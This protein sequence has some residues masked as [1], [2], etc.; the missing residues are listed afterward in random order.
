MLA[1]K[2]C[3]N[4]Y[5]IVNNNEKENVTV[6]VTGNAAGDLAPTFILFAGKSLPRNAADMAPAD[7]V[8]GCSD[9]GYMTSQNFYEYMANFFEPWL[10]ECR[11]K[12]PVLFYVDRHVWHM[13]LH[14]S[15]FCADRGIILIGLHPN[16]THLA[17]PLDV[18]LFHTLKDIWFKVVREFCEKAYCIGIEKYQFSQLMKKTLETLNMKKILENGFRRCGLH[19]FDVEGIDYD[20]VFDRMEASN[21]SSAINSSPLQNESQP[22]LNN[23]LQV[24]ESLL[25]TEQLE[26]FKLNTS[27]IWAGLKQDENL[28]KMWYNLSHAEFHSPNNQQV[29]KTIIMYTKYN[30]QI[31]KLYAYIHRI[32]C[33]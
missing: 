12:R 9:K 21:N 15:T 25:S 26:F 28:F 11:I 2:G 31:F 18:A 29:N 33:L 20:K 23:S 6:L 14:L 16:A 10:T 1:P 5:T 8:F 19:P 4:V 24:L 30:P 22:T 7:F 32:N 27:P 3:K 17:Q 13:T